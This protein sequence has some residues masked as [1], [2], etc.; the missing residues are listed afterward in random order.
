MRDNFLA[1]SELV[2]NKDIDL[3]REYMGNS[4]CV[5]ELLY[6][7]TTDGFQCATYHTKVDGK[8]AVIVLIKSKTN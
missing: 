5:T 3:L 1:G 4:Y 7:G 2:K 8:G 6:R